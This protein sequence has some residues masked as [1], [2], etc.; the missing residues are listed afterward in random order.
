MSYQ[1]FQ[2]KISINYQVNIM[3]GKLMYLFLWYVHLAFDNSKQTW[4]PHHLKSVIHYNVSVSSFTAMS[5]IVVETSHKSKGFQRSIY[6]THIS[7]RFGDITAL[8]KD[9]HF[10]PSLLH[11]LHDCKL[12]AYI[13]VENDW[14][15][16]NPVLTSSSVMLA[17]AVLQNTLA[18]GD[19]SLEVKQD[20]TV[21]TDK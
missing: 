10:H 9:W 13:N 14:N 18:D 3:S 4:T 19:Q 20:Q 5:Q 16:K 7:I 8:T 17:W 11:C 2:L 21:W 15:K 6:R 1:S 12:K